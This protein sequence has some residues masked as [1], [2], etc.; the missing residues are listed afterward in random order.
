MKNLILI[1]AML[2]AIDSAAQSLAERTG[3]NTSLYDAVCLINDIKP[4]S[5]GMTEGRKLMQLYAQSIGLNYELYELNGENN[6]YILH[7]VPS[8]E[9][10]SVDEDKNLEDNIN[11]NQANYISSESVIL[12]ADILN[13]ANVGADM[14]ISTQIEINPISSIQPTSINQDLLIKVQP[15][16]TLNSFFTCDCR[17]KDVEDLNQYYTEL[18]RMRHNTHGL[19]KDKLDACSY[20]LRKYKK[21]LEQKQ[22]RGN[23]EDSPSVGVIDG[24]EDTRVVSVG[25]AAP[26]ST[27]SNRTRRLGNGYAKGKC[28]SLWMKLFPFANC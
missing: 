14:D 21:V 9:T 1:V 8:V 19:L 10:I 15:V 13:T 17:D 24:N 5:I 18:L 3:E 11:D 6:L 26:R 2:F 23:N 25:R 16:Y 12:A 27:K 28:N 20:Q 4:G 22:R 7:F